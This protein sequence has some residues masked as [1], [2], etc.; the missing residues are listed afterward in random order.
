MKERISLFFKVAFDVF[1]LSSTRITARNTLIAGVYYISI[2]YLEKYHLTIEIHVPTYIF[3]LLGYVLVMLLYYTVNTAYYRW[4]EARKCWSYLGTHAKNFAIKLSAVLE[5]ND[6]ENRNFF[7]SMIVNHV[8]ALKADLRYTTVKKNEIIE[9]EPGL[10]EIVKNDQDPPNYIIG[11][12]EA[13]LN[14]LLK[15]GKLATYQFV[16]LNKYISEAIELVGQCRGIRKVPSPRSYKFHL[17]TFLF[18]FAVILPFGFIHEHD[19]LMILVMIVIYGAYEGCIIISEE[20][21]E[22]FGE[23]EYDIPMEDICYSI[24]KHVKQA[25]RF[26]LVE[27]TNKMAS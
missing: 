27:P 4:Y 20:V 18:L 8:Y 2:E 7:G 13:R 25:L 24:K 11:R 21:D 3:Y 22:P 23:D 14:E 9:V 1:S 10:Y 17:R 26:E 16:N 15:Q 5:P 6:S 19:W 12:I